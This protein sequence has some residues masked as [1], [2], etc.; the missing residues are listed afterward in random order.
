LRGRRDAF[1]PLTHD[2]QR[3]FGQE[4]QH[5]AA[6]PDGELPQ[7]GGAGSDPD[8][9]RREE[10]L[11]YCG[12]SLVTN[13]F[14]KIIHSAASDCEELAIVDI[15]PDEVVA[16]RHRRPYFRDRRPESYMRLTAC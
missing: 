5:R 4:E 10:K 15:D 14:G 6:T 8:G 11:A 3:V 2:G 12:A 13:P 7:A 9:Q 16:A 1:Q